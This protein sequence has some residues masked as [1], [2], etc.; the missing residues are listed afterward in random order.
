MNKEI[1]KKLFE[2]QKV[3]A[4]IKKEATNPFY[5]SKYFDIN[6]M[7]KVLKPE[8][9]KRNLLLMQP[10]SSVNGN[11]AIRTM[12]V[13]S[14]TGEMFEEVTPIIELKDPQKAGGCITYYRRYALQSMFALEA[15]D[16]DA[17]AA[18]GKSA[19]KTKSTTKKMPF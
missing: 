5:N 15:E 17:N 1:A 9:H 7:L 16:D 14:E 13:C 8:L 11:P 19:P 18:S 12:L 2:I 3:V 6:A 10:L 4:G